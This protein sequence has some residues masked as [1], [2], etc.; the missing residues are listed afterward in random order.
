[1]S[2]RLARSV[3]ASVA[4]AHAAMFIVYQRPDWGAQWTDQNG[5]L[6]LGRN[7]ADTGRYTRFPTSLTGST[8]VPEAIR[9]PIYPGFV[10]LLDLAF[11]ESR[12]VISSAQALLFA[13][14]CLLVYEIARAVTTERV[15]VAAG[16]VTA[17]Y[18]PLPY[19]GA[20]VLTE[21]FTTFLVT[22]GIAVWLAAVRTDSTG[23]F[24]ASGVIFGAT[25]LTRP[26]FEYLP[27]FLVAAAVLA[28]RESRRRRWR[29]GAIMLATSCVVIAPWLAYNVAYFKTLTFTPAGGPGRQLFE[30]SWQ[31]ELPGRVEAELTTLAD[32]NS[33]R[34]ELDDK[35]RA[36]AARTEMAAEPM[37]RYVHQHQD[38]RKI[39]V[40]PVDPWQ[41]MLARIEADH[42]YFRVGL[43]NIRLHPLRHL[44]RR[45]TRG[46]F[47]LWA[48]EIPVR[49]SDINRLSP[50][51]IRAIWLV[52][53][54]L[55]LLAVAGVVVL[56]REGAR[57]ESF[58]MAALI[59]YVSAVHVPLYSEAR[60]SLP[61]KP[62]VLLLAA[63]AVVA[64]AER[65][66]ASRAAKR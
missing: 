48:A 38:I 10:A 66:R 59:L 43:E 12:I 45:A 23:L 37:L 39:W 52:Q 55:M 21:V 28:A 11:G 51:T 18:P 33:N 14:I 7:L 40:E 56:A 57:T 61:A 50:L 13:I 64:A 17:L 41:R 26:A 30:G 62:I 8:Y 2:S 9:T 36:V 49:Y 31:A 15:A 19:F 5:Y 46:T 34:Q 29:G 58:A 35:V 54:A 4:I 60:Y 24:V 65:L 44:W 25:A 53:A 3:I 27:L 47:L 6:M 22:A 20:L 32:A 42:E 63:A 1:M 16:L